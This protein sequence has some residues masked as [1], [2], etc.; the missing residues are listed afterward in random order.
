MTEK[1]Q[2]SVFGS[3]QKRISDIRGKP[4]VNPR[5]KIRSFKVQPSLATTINSGSL[6]LCVGLVVGLGLAALQVDA[7][8]NLSHYSTDLNDPSVTPYVGMAN[9]M[10]SF[11]LGLLISYQTNGYYLIVGW[12][13]GG[14]ISSLV[15]GRKGVK[16]TYYSTIIA[17]SVTMG[18]SLLMGILFL[19]MSE[20]GFAIETLVFSMFSVFLLCIILT[21]ISIP[22]IIF[23]MLGYRLGGYFEN[24]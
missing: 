12:F 13:L 20:S 16:G 15:Y 22:L 17:I 23:A 10:I 6:I 1:N 3:L 14:F 4:K 11:T 8:L 2:T 7:K 19:T 24:E 5:L 9:L 21:I 18:I